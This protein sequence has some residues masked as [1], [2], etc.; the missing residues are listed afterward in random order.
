M[1]KEVLLSQAL[2][3][4][5]NRIRYFVAEHL[6]Q[7]HSGKYV[8]ETSHFGLFSYAQ[9]GL[10]TVS[11]DPAAFSQLTTTWD[12]TEQPLEVWGK[13]AWFNVEWQNHKVDVLQLSC[14]EGGYCTVT[15]QWIIAES[16]E[17]AEAFYRAVCEWGHVVHQE[18]MVFENGYWQKS[19][20]LYQAIQSASFDNLILPPQ[21]KQEFRE[22]LSRFFASREM[23]EELGVPWKRGVLLIGPPGNGKTHAVKAIVNYLGNTC[24]YVKTFANQHGDETAIKAVFDM[25]R[26]MAPC[27]L[28]LEDLDSLVNRGTRSF[29]LNELDGFTKNSGIAVVATTNYPE[30]LDPAILNR[31][32]RFDHKYY[33]KLPTEAERLAFLMFWNQSAKTQLQL[34]DRGAKEIALLT[35]GF[36]FAYLKELVLSSLM[37]WM[38]EPA[39]ST[40]DAV[41]KT[42]LVLLREQMR[43]NQEVMAAAAAN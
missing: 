18:I 12:G 34:S 30:K 4:S 23:Y 28:V 10:C 20:E 7:S 40:M 22:D 35:D 14:K 37:Q 3:Q 39:D 16:R 6:A 32:S 9:A 43:E 36:S 31:P 15:S 13:N 41:M 21:F 19:Q 2:K 5:E 33:F 8:L 1:N 25:A 17:V 42:Q 26:Q 11:Y 29:F 27:V 24:L 38:N